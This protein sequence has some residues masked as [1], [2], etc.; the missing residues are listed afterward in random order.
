MIWSKKTKTKPLKCKFFN[1]TEIEMDLAGSAFDA[2]EAILY[3][4]E[5]LLAHHPRTCMGPKRKNK[6]KLTTPN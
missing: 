3:Y 2:N 1:N 6:L 4:A 5:R